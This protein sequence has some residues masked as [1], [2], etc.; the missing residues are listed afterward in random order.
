MVGAQNNATARIT[1]SEQL[2]KDLSVTYS[3]DLATNKQ[4]VIQ[5]EYFITKNISV[6]ASKDENDVRA[7][8]LRIRRRF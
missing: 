6:L 8:D 2:T 3:Q 1:L 5:I 7:L 4:Q